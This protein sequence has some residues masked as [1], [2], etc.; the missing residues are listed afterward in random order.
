MA[1]QIMAFSNF[2]SDYY[3]ADGTIATR[4]SGVAWDAASIAEDSGM[5]VDDVTSFL[6]FIANY[7]GYTAAQL[8]ALNPS[9]VPTPIGGIVLQAAASIPATGGTPISQ[10]TPDQLWAYWHTKN[11][12]VF[13]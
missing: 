13:L 2:V 12:A 3:N 10:L 6:T 8:I 1:T 7:P 11:P 9:I 5:T 4:H